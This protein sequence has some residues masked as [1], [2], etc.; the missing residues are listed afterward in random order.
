MKLN[1]SKL[2]FLSF[3]IMF[4]FI[5]LTGCPEQ[6]SS[7]NTS[8]SS[9]N[10]AGFSS[11]SVSSLAAAS[12]I[13]SIVLS[14]AT[15]SS[16]NSASVFSSTA[17][18][19]SSISS[20]SSS[21]DITAFGFPAQN[22]KGRIA[23]PNITVYV[24]YAT[25]VTKLIATFTTTGASVLVGSVV[26]VSA[27]TVNDFT[28]P[29]TYTVVAQDGSKQDY[30]VTVII[31]A[32]SANAYLT[33]IIVKDFSGNV[34]VFNPV[35][36]ST[37]FI[38]PLTISD[39]KAIPY[40]VTPVLSDSTATISS[41]TENKIILKPASG[42]YT[43]AAAVYQDPVSITVIAQDGKTTQTYTINLTVTWKG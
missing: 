6:K 29:L 37:T 16:S 27:Q 42:V 34:Y 23:A 25:D 12:S 33:D 26:Q 39:Q 41:V 10:P 20:L 18:T 38:Y 32:A 9:V 28:K 3:I 5:F 14:S 22:A 21:K 31:N 17:S 43:L 11:Q 8:A 19:S 35:F 13:S 40:T 15:S 36:N 7:E 2:I 24:P 30:T 1:L 4:S